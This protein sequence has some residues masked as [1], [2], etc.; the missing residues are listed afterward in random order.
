M[1]TACEILDVPVT[2][3]QLI[4]ARFAESR[5]LRFCVEFG[6]LNVVE[7]ADRLLDEECAKIKI[8]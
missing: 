5:G 7:K 8:Q 1:K 4:A 2:K 6:I 3:E